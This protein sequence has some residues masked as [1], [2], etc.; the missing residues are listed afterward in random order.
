MFF[1]FYYCNLN[2]TGTVYFTRTA[3]P[4]CLPGLHLGILL[5]T[6]EASRSSDGSTERTTLTSVIEPSRSTTNDTITRPCT[7]FS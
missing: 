5:T 2:T 1:S 7:P 6:R 4:F 3:E